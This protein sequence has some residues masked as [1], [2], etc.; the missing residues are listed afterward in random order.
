MWRCRAPASARLDRSVL[1]LQHTNAK[2]AGVGGWSGHFAD[3]P[4]S[5]NHAM[6]FP[7]LLRSHCPGR[8]ALPTC[9]G[10]QINPRR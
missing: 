10:P 2:R 1:Y 6:Q 5:T 4:K 7:D 3:V 8:G 9:P